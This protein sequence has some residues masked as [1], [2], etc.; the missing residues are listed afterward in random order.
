M[1]CPDDKANLTTSVERTVRIGLRADE[2][3]SVEELPK[4]R[5]RHSGL[6]KCPG[7][8]HRRR[9]NLGGTARRGVSKPGKPSRSSVRHRLGQALAPGPPECYRVRVGWW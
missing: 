2:S 9:S 8:W 4:L 3:G 6:G 7:R 5:S 1:G